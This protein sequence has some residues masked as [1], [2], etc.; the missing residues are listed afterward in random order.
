MTAVTDSLTAGMFNFRPNDELAEI[1]GLEFDFDNLEQSVPVVADL[2][3]DLKQ[4]LFAVKDLDTFAA[5]ADALAGFQQQ[6]ETAH[7]GLGG[8]EGAAYDF[9]LMLVQAEGK[10]REL[11]QSS[12]EAARAGPLTQADWA[13]RAD[14]FRG[15]D[16]NVA[17]VAILRAVADA[18]A[19]AAAS[20]AQ[21]HSADN[22][23]MQ[24]M[25]A[26]LQGQIALQFMIN[27]YGADSLVVAQLRA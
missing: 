14:T 21:R 24:E 18:E 9:W 10:M 17:R 7:G 11:A 13:T 3:A 19:A 15:R 23:A 6:I 2:V 4:E 12:G 20:A 27:Q 5:Q 16:E 8:L 25:H 1:F 22:A 26:G